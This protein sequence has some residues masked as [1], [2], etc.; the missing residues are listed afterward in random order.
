MAPDPGAP[1]QTSFAATIVDQELAT[2]MG[3]SLIPV[4]IGPGPMVAMQGVSFTARTYVQVSAP[5]ASAGR[6]LVVSYRPTGQSDGV[7]IYS[8]LQNDAYATPET[9]AFIRHMLFE[10]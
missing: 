3:L 10:L 6:P 8:S 4:N 1:E 2:A 7:A 5:A 9:K